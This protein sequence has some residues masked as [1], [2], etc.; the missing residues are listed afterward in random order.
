MN[1]N[2]QSSLRFACL[3]AVLLVCL[4][5][6]QGTGA[7]ESKARRWAVIVGVNDYLNEV[8]PLRCAVNDAEK[9]RDALIESARFNEKDIFL[10]TSGEPGNR[11]PTRANIIKRIAYIKAEARRDD[12]FIFFFSGHGMDA[13]EARK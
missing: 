5:P 1:I 2:S 4:I 13:E 11:K 3:F 6:A 8:T 7:A 12:T 9:F 10:L